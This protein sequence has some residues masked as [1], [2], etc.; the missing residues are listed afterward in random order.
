MNDEDETPVEA[1][2]IT[3]ASQNCY[4]N[5]CLNRQ[6][7]RGLATQNQKA[8]SHSGFLNQPPLVCNSQ[9]LFEDDTIIS[10]KPQNQ[11]FDVSSQ[12]LENDIVNFH[13]KATSCNSSTVSLQCEKDHSAQQTNSWV[14]SSIYNSKGFHDVSAYG[15]NQLSLSA[16]SLQPYGVFSRGPSLENIS[17][18]CDKDKPPRNNVV[19]KF[20]NFWTTAQTE[21]EIQATSSQISASDQTR[22]SVEEFNPITRPPGFPPKD[23]KESAQQRREYEQLLA[24]IRR[25]DEKDAHQKLKDLKLKEKLISELVH[26]WESIYIPKFSSKKTS[27]GILDLVWKGIPSKLRGKIWILSIGN[28]LNITKHLYEVYFQEANQPNSRNVYPT[29]PDKIPA[30]IKTHCDSD[31]ILLDL[32]RTF[33]SLGVFQQGGPYHES[34]KCL[35]SIYVSHRPDIGYV[36]GMSFIASILLINMDLDQAFICMANLLNRQILISFFSMKPNL[37]QPYFL[38]FDHFLHQVLPEVC[39]H[40]T[41]IAFSSDLYLYEWILT[42]YSKSVS[43]DVASRIWDN[44][45]FHGDVFL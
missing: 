23:P 13:M 45:L 28:E 31:S 8:A 42:L 19:S 6:T 44:Y 36:Q 15:S 41:K 25:K 9:T 29:Q 35:L 16:L 21:Q 43:L 2:D 5:I 20:R 4:S 40:F 18:V 14:S 37:I 27:R 22:N 39:T 11:E 32:S 17:P 24:S 3:T 33:P 26:K 34:L 38:A 10:E 12:I 30:S 1:A 7:A